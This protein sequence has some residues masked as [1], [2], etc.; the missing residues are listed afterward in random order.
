MNISSS[1]YISPY[2]K[3]KAEKQSKTNSLHSVPLSAFPTESNELQNTLQALSFSG[4]ASVHHRRALRT[5]ISEQIDKLKLGSSKWTDDAIWTRHFVYKPVKNDRMKVAKYNGTFVDKPIELPMYLYHVTSCA[6]LDKIMNSG[7][8]RTSN[9]EQLTGVYLLDK[10]NFME[11]YPKTKTKRYKKRDLFSAIFS[12][13]GKSAGENSSKYDIA[14]IKIPTIELLELGKLRVRTQK[15]FFDFDDK[16]SEIG[17]RLNKKYRVR[18]LKDDNLRAEFQHDVVEYGIM[19]KEEMEQFIDDMTDK[20]HQGYTLQKMY[21]LA[22]DKKQSVEYIYNKDIP[23]WQI[24]GLSYSK[25]NLLYH[26]G[27]DKRTVDVTSIKPFFE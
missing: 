3:I 8:I 5:V 2:N 9:N 20:L 10:E 14:I 26:L 13:A 11:F 17:I 4:L 16:V 27:P 21:D 6:A 1:L 23:F 22:L 19:Q 25:I 18:D 24:S 15:D 7:K 12:Q